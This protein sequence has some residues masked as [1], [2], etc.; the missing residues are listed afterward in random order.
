M[1]YVFGFFKIQI[2]VLFV[3][4]DVLGTLNDLC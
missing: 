4:F 1:A 3:L 2:V